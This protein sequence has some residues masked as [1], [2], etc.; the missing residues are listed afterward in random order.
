METG[1]QHLACGALHGLEPEMMTKAKSHVTCMQM[2]VTSRDAVP[3]G[4]MVARCCRLLYWRGQCI[5]PCRQPGRHV[6]RELACA[7]QLACC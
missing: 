5:G 3:N 2:R 6:H 4:C 7:L 1:E